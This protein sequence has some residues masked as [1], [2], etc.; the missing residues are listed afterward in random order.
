MAD[1]K[2]CFDPPSIRLV[3]G[4]VKQESG[5]AAKRKGKLKENF[6]VG[7]EEAEG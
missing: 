2:S 3:N 1:V 5:G 6:N 7:G 4:N